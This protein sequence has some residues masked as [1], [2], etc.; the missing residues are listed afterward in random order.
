MKFSVH[1]NSQQGARSQ[2]EDRLAYCYTRQSC[3]FMLADGMGGHP[4][5]ATA[6][7]LALQ[8]LGLRFQK[9]AQPLLRQVSSFLSGSLLHAHH[10]IVSYAADKGMLDTPRTTLV[11][12]V[13]ERN[14]LQAIHCGDSRLYLV[15][16]GRLV[17]RTRD[18]S[19]LERRKDVP[20]AEPGNRN[21]LF[22]CLGS[23]SVPVFEMSGPVDL[24]RGDRLLL[25]SDGLWSAMG[26]DEL[27]RA[28]AQGALDVAVDAMVDEALRRGGSR[29]DNVSALAVEWETEDDFHAT[30]VSTDDMRE[31]AFS[32]TLDA[33]AAAEAHESAWDMDEET[34]ERTI[35]EINEAIRKTAA[36]KT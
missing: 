4:Q 26:D 12:A 7:H 8:T 13:I 35:A 23:P 22:S 18:H 11:A 27:V 20:G 16:Q 32:S 29:A 2:N 5:G 1:Q 28:L 10:H 15:R 34:I 9:M 6:A 17:L 24:Q 3:L 31:G 30:R 33:H 19:M 14:Q 25:C 36:R 21:L